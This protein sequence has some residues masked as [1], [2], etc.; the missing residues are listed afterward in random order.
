MDS[1]RDI[2]QCAVHMSLYW[3]W[4]SM[5]AATRRDCILGWP[6][7]VIQQVYNIVCVRGDCSPNLTPIAVYKTG[8]MSAR[9]D[10]HWWM[11]VKG[12]VDPSCT[13]PPVL[14]TVPV[15]AS[16][17]GLGF[18]QALSS[19]YSLLHCRTWSVHTVSL[20]AAI[21]VDILTPYAM[22]KGREDACV[23][24]VSPLYEMHAEGISLHM[25]IFCVQVCQSTVPMLIPMC[26]RPLGQCR[27]PS[28]HAWLC[29]GQQRPTSAR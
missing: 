19:W 13:Q 25:Q 24:E 5:L 6:G 4:N 7:T 15:A 23:C 9:F 18:C 1:Q 8:V 14:S 29:T 22:L 17:R 11:L 10:W 20:M 3:W 12:Y 16:T 27:P 2:E 21:C 26:K 28:A